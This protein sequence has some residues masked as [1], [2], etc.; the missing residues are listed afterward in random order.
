[1]GGLSPSYA[2]G[3]VCAEMIRC[4]GLG[5]AQHRAASVRWAVCLP[6]SSWS[7]LR[8]L[9]L[10]KWEHSWLGRIRQ[11]SVY[12]IFTISCNYES[13]PL[14]FLLWTLCQNNVKDPKKRF[15]T[16]ACA[17]GL[18]TPTLSLTPAAVHT[19]D[20]RFALTTDPRMKISVATFIS[21]EAFSAFGCFWSFIKTVAIIGW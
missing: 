20:I 16:T 15:G 8:T 21:L 17:W 19:S 13:P 2:L 3:T 1:M 11:T 7:V 18:L 5:G 10:C 12:Q 6:Q 4:R 9:W 14:L